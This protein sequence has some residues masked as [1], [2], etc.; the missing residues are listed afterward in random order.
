MFPWQSYECFLL[1]SYLYSLH[2]SSCS[3]QKHSKNLFE[4]QERSWKNFKWL[5]KDIFCK[6]FFTHSMLMYVLGIEQHEFLEK[7]CKV[8]RHRNYNTR[9]WSKNNWNT[10]LTLMHDK[11]LC[12]IL[13]IWEC[14][15]ISTMHCKNMYNYF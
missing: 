10:G 2:E 1:V 7:S 3:T 9:C 5:Y 11:R 13:Q 14:L 15:H 8:I 4:W 12:F 6:L